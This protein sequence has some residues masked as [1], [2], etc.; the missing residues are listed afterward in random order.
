MKMNDAVLAIAVSPN[1]KH[2]AVAL[3][4]GTVK[5][6]YMDS[7]KFFLS[8]YGHKLPVSCLDISTDGDLLIFGDCHKSIFAH[9]A[10]VRA[11]KFL[12][13]THYVFSVGNDRLDLLIDPYADGIELRNLFSSR[14]SKK[15]GWRKCLNLILRIC[16]R[17]K[18]CQRRKF[19]RKELS[20][21][22]MADAEIKRLADHEEEKLKGKLAHFRPN[23]LM[24]GLSPS[25]FMLRAISNVQTNDLE[26]TLLALPFSDALKLLSH[27]KDWA[28][29][30]DKVE[31]VGRVATLLLQLHRNQLVSTVAAKPVLTS[32]KDI[33]PARVKECKDTLGF[34]L[35]VMDH[36]KQLM[37]LRS[38]APFRD[39]KRADI[40]EK[41]RKK[42][43]K[44]VDGTHVWS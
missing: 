38:D 12:R 17:I 43:Q 32:L 39:A 24:L 15:K 31:L 1:G 22:D 16:L 25:D 19:Q 29:I 8:L 3:A 28:T 6:Y 10:S 41:K 40:K 27:L 21:L 13:N 34:N 33:I 5:V 7:H 35:A 2:I 42:K 30:P 18:V 23:I 37:A 36:L 9:A 20:A 4:D 26:L 44:E 14:K 11:V